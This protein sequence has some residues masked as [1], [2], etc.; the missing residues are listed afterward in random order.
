[1]EA[2]GIPGADETSADAFRAFHRALRLHRRALTQAFAAHGVHHGQAMCLRLLAGSGELTQRDLAGELHVSSPTVTRM[3]TSME[4]A[5]LVS[6]SPDE[7]DA[8]LVRVRLTDAG[9]VQE[10]HIRAAAGEYVGRTFATLPV[11]ERL[12]LARLLDKLSDRIAEAAPPR[13]VPDLDAFEAGP[14]DREGPESGPAGRP[15]GGARPGPGGGR[16]AGAGGRP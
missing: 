1:M 3:V 6:R 2:G 16:A 12:E 15:S 4:R 13:E 10:R 9:R 11:E 5:G 8:R 14:D 7:T